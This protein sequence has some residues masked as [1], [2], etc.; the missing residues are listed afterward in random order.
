MVRRI[1]RKARGRSRTRGKRWLEEYPG[2]LG[3]G[4]GLKAKDG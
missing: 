1:S 2:R 3:A 4:L